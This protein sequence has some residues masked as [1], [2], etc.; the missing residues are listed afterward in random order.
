MRLVRASR[1]S[2]VTQFAISGLLAMVLIGAIAV[3]ITRQA[4]TQQS[5]GDAKDVTRLAGEGIVMPEITGGVVA[6]D[7]AALRRLD[8]IVRAR[9]LRDNIVRVKL[10]S[11]A[12]AVIYSDE[13]RLIGARYP[14]ED[15]EA[16]SLRGNRVEAEVSDLSRPEN[17]YERS[18]GKLLEVYLPLRGPAGQPLLFEAYQRFSSVSAGGRRLWL[19]F[20]PALVGGLLLLWLIN[21]PLARSLAARLR[22]GQ[23]ERE[24]LLRHA[25]D[26]SETERRVIAADLHDGV[27]QDL[28]GVSFSLAAHAE[29]MNGGDGAAKQ[30]LQEG[31]AATRH[32]VRALRTLLVEIYPPSLHEA[33]LQATLVDLGRTYTTRG[34][35]TSVDIDDVALGEDAERLLFRSAQELLRNAHQHGHADTAAITI[36]AHGDH[37]VMQVRD[38]G[39]G[40]DPAVL[41]DRPGQGHFGLRVLSDL[42][43]DAGGRVDVTSFPGHG[44]TVRV[45]VPQ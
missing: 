31:A 10:W 38:D 27:V 9:V 40:F 18:A 25:L 44:T 45:E 32:S 22:Q 13:P 4:G 12:G 20:A 35:A 1:I 16:D 19:A 42:M 43:A 33:G 36:H 15:E 3:A 2:P 24:Q 41:A 26:A 34:L 21:L 23:R 11:A 30:A 5:I 28:V 39:R 29:R 6:G 8:R 37:A 17:R 7:P 14:L